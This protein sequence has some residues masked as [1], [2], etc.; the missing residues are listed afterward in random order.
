MAQVT[1]VAHLQ[2][3]AQE[4]PHAAGMAKKTQLIVQMSREMLYHLP[5]NISDSPSR[6]LEGIYFEAIS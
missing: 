1:A 6:N 2:S 3:L 5:A 4:L